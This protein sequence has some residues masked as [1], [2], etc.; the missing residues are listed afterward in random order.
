MDLE[1]DSVARLTFDFWAYGWSD[2]QISIVQL[3]IF[4]TVL[5]LRGYLEAYGHFNQFGSGVP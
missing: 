4:L 1:F 5:I 3:F 2:R